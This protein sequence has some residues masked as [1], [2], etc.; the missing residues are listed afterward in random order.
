MEYEP[1]RKLYYMDEELYAKTYETRFHAEDAVRLDFDIGGHPAFF[2]QTTEVWHLAYAI[3]RLDKRVA[4]LSG[5]LPRV[6]KKQYSQKCLIDEIVVTN[7]IEGVHSSRKDIHDALEILQ[8][9]SDRR[10]NQRFLGLVNKYQKLIAG[11]KIPLET[12]ADVR[13]IYDEVFLEEILTED[14]H[15]APDG[16]IFRK[17]STAVHSETDRVIHTGL[18]PEDAIITAM[19]K[20]L[21]F[22]RDE[23]VEQLFRV[24]IFHYLVEYIHPFYDGN[25][26]MGRFILSYCLSEMLEPLLAY[27]LSGTIK[28]GISAYYKAF[29]VCNDRKNLGDLTPFLLMMLQMIYAALKDLESSLDRRLLRWVRYEALAEHFP[30]ADDGDMRNLYSC[31]IQAA[32]FSEKGISTGELMQGLHKTYYVIRKMLSAIPDDLLMAQRKGKEKYYQMNLAVLDD[33]LL[34]AAKENGEVEK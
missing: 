31:L 8:K 16:K 23:S 18:Y 22:L 20:A 6:A 19:E 25:G 4:H 29:V 32:L 14:P 11:E 13:A 34:E 17:E 7:K 12:C 24:C 2:V 15:N 1:L 3:A 10:R 30:D 26:R 33:V 5:Q 9:Q 21:A 28:E 27:R